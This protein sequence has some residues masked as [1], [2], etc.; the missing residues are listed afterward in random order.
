MFPEPEYDLHLLPPEHPAWNAEEI[1]PPE[2]HR[3]LLGVDYGC[4][5]CLVYAPPSDAAGPGP[6]VPSLSCLWELGGP[7]RDALAP[8]VRREVDAALAIG[9]NVLAYATNREVKR[10]D[11]LFALDPA[12]DRPADDFARGQLTIGKLK[13]GG[14]CDAAPAALANILRAAAREVGIRVDDAPGQIDPS[15]ERLFDHHLVFMHGRQGFS[16]DAPRRERLA[17]FL[18]R[19]GML[20]A[21][22]VCAA[23]SFTQAFRTEIAAMLPDHRLEEIPADDPIFTAAEYGGYDIRE[24]T[25]REPA[26]GGDAALGVRKR[27]ITPRLEGVRIGDRWA[28]IFSPFDLSCALE[29]QNSMEC[30]GYGRDDAERIALN[31]LLYSLNH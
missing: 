15:D 1:V 19:G 4:R 6:P 30:T 9:A 13:H 31:V 20:L 8:G 14:M 7:S 11:E 3:P 24:V 29:K 5:T 23:S 21:D 2:L 10:K 26:G 18:E 16:F 22:S 12:D 17:T 27:T 25:L 28:V